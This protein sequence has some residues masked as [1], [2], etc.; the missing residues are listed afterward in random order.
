MTKWIL[1]LLVGLNSILVHSK[2]KL[3]AIF[4]NNMVLQQQTEISIRGFAEPNRKVIIKTSWDNKIYKTFSHVSGAFSCNIKTPSA[5]GP[6]NIEISDGEKLVLEGVLIGEVWICSGQSNME[7]PVKGFRG[8]PVDDSQEAIMSANPNRKLRLFTV[9]RNYNVNPQDDCVGE[10]KSPDSEAVSE[11]SATAYFF[12]EQLEKTLNVP[13]GLVH[14]SWSAS[15]IETW[16]DQKTLS[17]FGEVDLSALDNANFDYPNLI[18][19]LLFNGMIFPLK[20][21]AARG[22][23]WYQGESNSNNPEL[24]RKLFPALV[25]QWR[26]FFNNQMLPFYYVQI[27]PYQSSGKDLLNLPVFRQCQLEMML[28]LPNVGMAFT[29][30]IG[31][32]FC[33]HPPQ[34]K[35]VGQRLAYWTLAKDYGIKG[36]A[37]SGPVFVDY[38][39]NGSK[40]Q[41]IFLFAEMGLSPENLNIAGFEVADESGVFV[42]ASAKIIN[43]TNKVEVWCDSIDKI[44]E[45]RYCY[46]N[47][48]EGNLFNTAGLP[49]APF[50]VLISDKAF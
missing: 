22:V 19:T 39:V 23:I 49:A 18:P 48:A 43:G 47:Y 9:K 7:M 37:Y 45:V 5:G 46:K 11:F 50:N 3:P 30:D 40:I 26:V 34:K 29:T 1:L 12:G 2:I 33:I 32:E 25:N 42:P 31:N 13:V 24:Y 21:I 44:K 10:W 8:Q 15:K 27:A 38:L 35:I 14:A 28:K 41:L 16:M 17:H 6:Y 20:G 4:A 36:I